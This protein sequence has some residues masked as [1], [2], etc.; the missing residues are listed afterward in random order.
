M[1]RVA[2]LTSTLCSS[3]EGDSSNSIKNDKQQAPATKCALYFFG[4][5]I[6]LNEIHLSVK[7]QKKDYTENWSV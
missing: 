7:V 6:I 5:N 2:V 4:E 1:N 3:N